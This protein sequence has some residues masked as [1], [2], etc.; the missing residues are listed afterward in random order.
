M[1]TF[2]SSFKNS[3]I[4]HAC[5]SIFAC[6]FPNKFQGT[7]PCMY[8]L[9]IL[10]NSVYFLFL[11]LLHLWEAFCLIIYILAMAAVSK[12]VF[13]TNIS[14]IWGYKATIIIVNLSSTPIWELCA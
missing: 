1:K 13:S 14:I 12:Y 8:T 6:V 3:R 4:L 10:N 2:C 11:L 7:P 5:L 9:A